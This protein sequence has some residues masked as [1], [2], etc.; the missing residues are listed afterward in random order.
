MLQGGS[1]YDLHFYRTKY[2]LA[3]NK[4]LTTSD[5]FKLEFQGHFEERMARKIL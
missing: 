1:L 2:M 3:L 4:G 5:C